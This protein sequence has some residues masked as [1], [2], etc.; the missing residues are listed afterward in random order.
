MFMTNRHTA[1][2][3]RNPQTDRLPKTIPSVVPEC[4]QISSQQV[5]LQRPVTHPVFNHYR[6]NS[7]LVKALR[8]SLRPPDGG[9]GWHRHLPLK[10]HIS[11]LAFFLVFLYVWGFF[12]YHG[13][14]P[15]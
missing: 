9:D 5:P 8:M 3:H 10:R 1:G 15:S 7:E 12:W 6:H 14:T 2:E 13:I 4:E 11:L